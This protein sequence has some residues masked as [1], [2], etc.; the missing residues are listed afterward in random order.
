MR[1]KSG[2]IKVRAVSRANKNQSPN[3]CRFFSHDPVARD[4][5][6]C[7]K[8]SRNVVRLIRVGDSFVNVSLLQVRIKY[9]LVKKGKRKLHLVLV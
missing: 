1:N 4:K 3:K 8:T 2:P 5:R 7:S 9:L 6:H